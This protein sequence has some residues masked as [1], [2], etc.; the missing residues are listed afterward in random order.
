MYA[1][2]V[3]N[4]INIYNNY[5]RCCLSCCPAD[6]YAQGNTAMSFCWS[7]GISPLHVS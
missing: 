5:G 3:Q 4:V 1:M 6:S 2:F 7:D